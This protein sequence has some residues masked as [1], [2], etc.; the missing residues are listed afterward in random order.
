MT[1]VIKALDGLREAG[2]DAE[3]IDLRTIR[4]MDVAT[5]RRER[6]EDERCVVVEE[7]FRKAAFPPRSR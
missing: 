1:Y 5:H 4:P 6:E 2:I 3:V 7:G